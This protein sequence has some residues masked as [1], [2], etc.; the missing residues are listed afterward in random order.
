[1]V[2]SAITERVEVR[3]KGTVAYLER[4]W[5]L[6]RKRAQVAAEEEGVG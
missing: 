5:A 2:L 6:E 1:M 4:K 3:Y